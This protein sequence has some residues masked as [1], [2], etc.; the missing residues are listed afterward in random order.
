MRTFLYYLYGRLLLRQVRGRDV[1]RHL[2]I[3]LDGNRRYALE[4]GVPDIREAYALGAE[5]LDEVL[6]WC[7]ETGIRAVS[8]WVFSTDNFHR[9]ATEVSGILSAVES[10]LIGS[11]A[12]RARIASA[13]ASEPSGSSISC[14]TRRSRLSATP[15][16]RPRAI[17][18]WS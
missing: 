18:R 1:P 2:G 13:S 3:I 14:R 17:G 8:L 15:R 5:K 12:I 10:K 11:L 6:E 16:K 4:R 7:A 9:S